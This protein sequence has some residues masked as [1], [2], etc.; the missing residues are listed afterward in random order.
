[1]SF[2][3]PRLFSRRCTRNTWMKTDS[4]TFSTRARILLGATFKLG[5]SICIS[6]FPLSLWQSS[7]TLPYLTH[8]NKTNKNPFFS[9]KN[10]ILV[11]F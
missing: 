11:D 4:C 3:P 8:S 9:A 7:T 10:C 6:S 5:P 1:M 2:L